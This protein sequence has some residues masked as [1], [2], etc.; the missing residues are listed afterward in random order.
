MYSQSRITIDCIDENIDVEKDKILQMDKALL[1]KSKCF[2][3]PMRM[4]FL[5]LIKR[6]NVV[7]VY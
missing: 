7:K 5:V 1:K 4:E 2:E 3:N 6:R